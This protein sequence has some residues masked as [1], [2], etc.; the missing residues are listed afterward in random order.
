MKHDPPNPTIQ[1]T[2]TSA[3]D[4]DCYTLFQLEINKSR[5]NPSSRFVGVLGKSGK[6]R[7]V[8]PKTRDLLPESEISEFRPPIKHFKQK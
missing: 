3:A 4:F 6:R 8:F 5:L 7:R 2:P 1:R